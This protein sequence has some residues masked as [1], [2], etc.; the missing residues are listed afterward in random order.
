MAPTLWRDVTCNPKIAFGVGCCSAPSAIIILAP[1][2]SP[3]GGI[4][5]AGWKMNFTLP[6]NCARRPASTLA[7]P[8]RIAVWQSW[9]QACITPTSSPFHMVRTFD[10]NGTSTSSVTGNASM[11]ARSATTLLG[12]APFSRPT[13]PVCATPVFTSSKPR[14]RRWSATIAAVRTSRLPS[15]GCWWKSRRQAM[16]RA[17]TACAALSIAAASS[18]AWTVVAASIADDTITDTPAVGRSGT[19]RH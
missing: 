18:L 13:T 6:R 12:S 10:A 4:S 14:L 16:T 3:W 5:S 11:S 15:S 9:P 7:T 2:S 8:I 17:S 19:P 1:P